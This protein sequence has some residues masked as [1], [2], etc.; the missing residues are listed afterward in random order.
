MLLRM[1]VRWAEGKGFKVET[2]DFQSGDEAGVK[3]ATIAVTGPP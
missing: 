1:Y 3:S 2:L